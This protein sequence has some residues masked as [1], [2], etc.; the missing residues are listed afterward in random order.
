MKKIK[1]IHVPDTLLDNASVTL[2][3]FSVIISAGTSPCCRVNVITKFAPF[4]SKKKKSCCMLHEQ[5][6]IYM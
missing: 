4:D 5:V 2:E 1:L 3:L 6:N